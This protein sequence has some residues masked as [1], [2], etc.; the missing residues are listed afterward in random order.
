[1]L[2][3]ELNGEDRWFTQQLVLL[4]VGFVL[5]VALAC[6]PMVLPVGAT[7]EQ[8]CPDSMVQ[9]ESGHVTCS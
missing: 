5:N 4:V 8:L 9:I 2:K 1:M 6:L 7:T 3:E